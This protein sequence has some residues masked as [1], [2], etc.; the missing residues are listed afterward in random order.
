MHASDDATLST[1]GYDAGQTAAIEP[2]SPASALHASL[3][4]RLAALAALDTNSDGVIDNND[5]S[6]GKF[7]IWQDANHDGVA[8]V[9]EL[10]SLG[11]HGI[12][13]IS[14]NGTL[15]ESY[16]DA[17][18]LLAQ[19]PDFGTPLVA[20]QGSDVQLA[21]LASLDI[22]DLLVG[23]NG[24]LDLDQALK[25]SLLTSSQPEGASAS[26]P[27][28]SESQPGASSPE[29]AQQ[30]ADAPPPANDSGGSQGASGEQGGQQNQ[31]QSQEAQANAG[32]AEA[33]AGP[34]HAEAASVTIQIDDG[35]EQAQNHAVA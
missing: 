2:G 9:S 25:A 33:D 31:S 11:D 7:A 15:V 32:P 18:S 17:Q 10:S 35:A 29:A 14:L 21:K 4:E 20:V 30:Q 6:Y 19:A 3:A 16:L 5:T 27:S 22:G 8:D 12:A 13:G 1:A 34:N 23:G 24:Y 26:G 28:A